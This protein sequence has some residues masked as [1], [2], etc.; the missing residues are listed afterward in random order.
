MCYYS[1]HDTVGERGGSLAVNCKTIEDTI[2]ENTQKTTPRAMDFALTCARVTWILAGQD[3][4]ALDN[5][6]E[7]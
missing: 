6:N 3:G 5:T 1:T 4:L 7:A 2:E